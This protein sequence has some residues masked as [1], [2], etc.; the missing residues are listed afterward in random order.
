MLRRR[1]GQIRIDKMIDTNNPMYGRH[2]SDETKR[3]ISENCRGFSGKSHTVKTKIAMSLL[4]KGEKN[5]FYNK[6]HSEKT[7][8]KMS[9]AS[10]G[11]EK[12]EEHKRKISIALSGKKKSEGHK[13]KLSGENN[14]NW[15]GGI[16]CEPYC[17]VWLDKEYK[18]LIKERDDYKCQN[19]D[20]W[21]SVKELLVHHIDYNKKN[22]IPNNLITLCRSCNGR[23][24]Y[25]RKYWQTLYENKIESKL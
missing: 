18:E 24:N 9:N 1:N 13:L 21:K 2:H 8:L 17:D 6:K 3:K 25:N 11:R 5:S 4:Q 15:K 19:P 23:A 14:Y 16:S 22:C 20:C 7:I 10:I 12:S